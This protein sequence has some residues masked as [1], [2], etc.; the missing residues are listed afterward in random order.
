MCKNALIYAGSAAVMYVQKCMSS[1][2]TVKKL[3]AQLGL[4]AGSFVSH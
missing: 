2:E 4:D 3:K 1:S